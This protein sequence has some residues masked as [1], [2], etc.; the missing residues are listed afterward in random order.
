MSFTLE[1]VVPWGRSFEE[2]VDMFALTQTDLT[3][4]ILGCGDGP[5]S[6]NATL[7]RQA[8]SVISIDPLYQFS[9]PDIKARIDTITPTVLQQTLENQHEF[10]WTR[11]ASPQALGQH[12]LQTME[13]FLAD[14][15]A[16]LKQ[17]RYLPASLP[18]LPFDDNQFDLALCSHFLFLYSPHFDAPFHLQSI[19][20]LCRVAK[21]ARIFPLLE[22][23]SKP[24][25]H[26][27]SVIADLTTLGFQ[28]TQET[29][30]YEL[31]KTGNQLLRVKAPA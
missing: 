10:V 6:F 26:L 11:F 3:S 5:A 8:G 24:S 1:N 31:Q 27:Q 28:V 23:G 29:V 19:R 14:Y 16:G 13:A 18:T 25:R 7:T 20:E 2:Y 17:G 12:R 9:G 30:N 15:P 21:E 22:L 4:R